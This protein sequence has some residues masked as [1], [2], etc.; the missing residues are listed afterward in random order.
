MR[1]HKL[2]TE[3]LGDAAII[4]WPWREPEC[5]AAVF[6]RDHP[7]FYAFAAARLG[8]STADDVAAET[9]VTAFDRR[10]RYGLSRPDAQPCCTGSRRT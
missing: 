7:Q 10:E 2:P 5:F 3:A 4:E 9:F 8:R 1:H 6:D